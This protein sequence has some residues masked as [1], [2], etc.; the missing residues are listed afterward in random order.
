MTAETTILLLYP[1]VAN[2]SKGQSLKEAF[3]ERD[4]EVHELVIEQN[5]VQV[6]NALEKAV[7]PVVVR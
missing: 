3:Q 2:K 1:A 5:Y 6:L 7:T 4:I